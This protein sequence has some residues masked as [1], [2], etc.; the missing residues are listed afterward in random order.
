MRRSE[1]IPTNL[2]V[3]WLRGRPIDVVALDI[4]LHGMFLRTDESVEPGSLMQLNVHLPDRS[5]P[6]FVTAR[7][8]GKTTSG[9]GIGVEIFLLDEVNQAHWTLYYHSML[10]GSPETPSRGSLGDD[11]RHVETLRSAND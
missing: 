5:I 2:K 8:C 4:N 9:V 6:L 11:S 10:Q 3:T 7:F 1:R